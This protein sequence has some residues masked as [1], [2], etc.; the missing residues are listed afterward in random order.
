V[1]AEFRDKRYSGPALRVDLMDRGYETGV[2]S[3]AE[4][5]VKIPPGARAEGDTLT[6][7]FTFAGE[8]AHGLF[9]ARVVKLDIP[10]GLMGAEFGW[11]S[12]SGVSL[13]KSITDR[14]QPGEHN[15]HPKMTLGFAHVTRNWSFSGFL[16][17]DYYGAFEAGQRFRGMIWMD[18]PED[19]GLFDGH[20]VGV[21]Q[22]RHTLSVKFDALPP[23]TF[24]LLEAVIHKTG[25]R[26]RAQ[27]E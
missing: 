3:A 20:V 15:N 8:S 17:D 9:E 21:D 23:N 19:P 5:I 2:W 4:L 26:A 13:L 25:R 18:L 1:K 11:I 22:H 12:Q 10:R 24:A 27:P 6:G 14:R 16:L 7:V